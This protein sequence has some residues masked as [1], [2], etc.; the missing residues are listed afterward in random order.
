MTLAVALLTGAIDAK[1][2]PKVMS[3]R[4]GQTIEDMQ[5]KLE[6]DDVS[7]YPI[8]SATKPIIENSHERKVRSPMV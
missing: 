7:N 1:L 4:S 3:L 8:I 2:R 5:K 6:E